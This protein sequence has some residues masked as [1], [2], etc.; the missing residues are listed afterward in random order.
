[1][2]TCGVDSPMIHFTCIYYVSIYI[3]DVH[4]CHQR[5]LRSGWFLEWLLDGKDVSA[6]TARP[7]VSR[8]KRKWIS[9]VQVLAL[10]RYSLQPPP[11]P[12]PQPPFSTPR[13]S[14][15]LIDFPLY[16]FCC[17]SHVRGLDVWVCNGILPEKGTN[18]PLSPVNRHFLLFVSFY[19]GTVH[20]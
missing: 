20:A 10:N 5:L 2:S 3:H 13:P 8:G 15:S 6:L 12:P 1:M 9:A 16:C 7:Q 11:P 18:L 17:C 14:S 4:V 19:T